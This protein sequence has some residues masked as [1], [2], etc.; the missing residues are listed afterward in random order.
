MYD[1]RLNTIVFDGENTSW[2]NLIN[3]SGSSGVIYG[4]VLQSSSMADD[5]VITEIIIDGHSFGE[6]TSYTG[7]CFDLSDFDNAFHG[8]GAVGMPVYFNDSVVVRGKAG[9]STTPT[10]P[11]TNASFIYWGLVT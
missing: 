2:Q 8:S 7:A 10:N 11:I 6:R 1:I 5:T 3:H 4:C 9:N